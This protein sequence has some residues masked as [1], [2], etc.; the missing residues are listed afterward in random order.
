MNISK[1]F[2]AKIQSYQAITVRA[3]R[4][5][6]ES[7]NETLAIIKVHGFYVGCILFTYEGHFHLDV[8]RNTQNYRFWVAENPQYCQ[9]RLLHS[10]KLTFGS[11][12]D[13]YGR[14]ARML[15]ILC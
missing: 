4:Q 11:I 5:R 3:V 1:L 14:K 6:E 15:S 13:F 9:A 7:A 12:L 8:F 2:L 10:E